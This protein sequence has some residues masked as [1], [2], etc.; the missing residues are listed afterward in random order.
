MRRQQRQDTEL[1]QIHDD[2]EIEDE[3]AAGEEVAAA[4]PSHNGHR[5]LN[6]ARAPGLL[7]I[8]SHSTI[9]S[10][11]IGLRE[12]RA[13]QPYIHASYGLPSDD[14]LAGARVVYVYDVE[15]NLRFQQLERCC[16]YQRE[17]AR[18]QTIWAILNRLDVGLADR[19]VSELGVQ[20]RLIG[21]A[22]FGPASQR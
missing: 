8:G 6:A 22:G 7:L 21:E 16:E 2:T 19:I 3:C 12:L 11:I 9:E 4:I 13:I 1:I 14:L 17:G 15:E 10:P 20:F 18:T 5:Y